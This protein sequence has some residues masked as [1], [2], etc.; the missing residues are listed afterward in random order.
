ML[1]GLNIRHSPS[2]RSHLQSRPVPYLIR[3]EEE[4]EKEA[5]EMCWWHLTLCCLYMLLCVAPGPCRW[6]FGPTTVVH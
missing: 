1:N 2:L 6:T 5:E 4:K 3:E